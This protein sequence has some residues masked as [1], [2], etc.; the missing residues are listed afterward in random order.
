MSNFRIRHTGRSDENKNNS[1]T[2]VENRFDDNLRQISNFRIQRMDRSKNKLDSMERLQNR[3]NGSTRRMS[4]FQIQRR[5][6]SNLK[7][8]IRWR[9]S[10]AD[11]TVTRI[12]YR[13]SEFD[14][15]TDRI[16]KKRF[17]GRRQKSI[18]RQHVSNT[19]FPISTHGPVE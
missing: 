14:A 18:R 12:E 15:W 11:S 8:P 7:K 3:F 13:V 17:Y 1:T 5:G 4:S 6:R 10:K 19:D 16:K 2:H 9:S